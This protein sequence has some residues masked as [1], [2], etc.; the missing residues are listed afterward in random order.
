MRVQG[1]KILKLGGSVLTDKSSFEVA[2]TE[3]IRE[4]CEAIAENP[5]NLILIHGAGSFG[6][7]HVRRYGIS[8]PKSVS[9][10]HVACLKLNV[11]LCESLAAEGVAA[12]PIHPFEGIDIERVAKL[13]E[14]GFV[15]VLHGDVVVRNG[16][17][18][19]SGDDIA[20]RI[21]EELGAELLGFATDVDG[22]YVGDGVVERFTSEMLHAVGAAKTCDVTGGMRRKIELA[23]KLRSPCRV[24]IFRGSGENVRTFLRGLPVGTEVVR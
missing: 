20:V 18:V 23:L 19:L 3:V 6:H 9:R 21:A 2:K 10:V 24:F 14:L 12:A 13:I 5:E 4:I 15:P 1:L 22:I 17:E 16:F 11:L 8:S 7:P